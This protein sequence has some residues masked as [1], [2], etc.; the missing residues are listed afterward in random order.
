[1]VYGYARRDLYSGRIIDR[2]ELA[3]PLS[4]DLE[5]QGLWMDFPHRVR[6]G[7]RFP[8]GLHALEHTSIHMLPA[9][10]GADPTETGGI[11]YPSGRMYFYDGFPGG[12]GLTRVAYERLEEVLAKALDRLSHCPCDRG[13]PGCVLDPQCGNA[14]DHLDKPAAR[15]ILERFLGAERE[16]PGL[17][18]SP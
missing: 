13:C 3:D 11:S 6:A 2:R 7:A 1:M 4:F 8:E 17:G 16:L 15:E 14:N 9:V 18:P 10:T 5:T 12:S